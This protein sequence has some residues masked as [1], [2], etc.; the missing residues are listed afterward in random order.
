MP[1]KTDKPS[2][3]VLIQ[4]I[5]QDI[6]LLKKDT[7]TIRNDLAYIKETLELQAKEEEEATMV[8]Q[9]ISKGWW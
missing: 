7:A 4:E 9:P 3:Q 8:V 5:I 2:N 1:D 6:Q